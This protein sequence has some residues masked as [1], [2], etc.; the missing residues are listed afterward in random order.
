M[1]EPIIPTK[2]SVMEIEN[3]IVSHQLCP[4]K[5]NPD[6]YCNIENK[7][8]SL[9]S[10]CVVYKFSCRLQ[11]NINDFDGSLNIEAT[12][13]NFG[14][15]LLNFYPRVSAECIYIGYHLCYS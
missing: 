2:I 14:C 5:L 4:V 9:C 8:I 11:N 10:L 3:L 15:F 13:L 6:F 7:T 12:L 1:E